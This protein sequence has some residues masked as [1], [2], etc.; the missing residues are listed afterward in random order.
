MAPRRAATVLRWT[1][2]VSFQA[3]TTT[4]RWTGDGRSQPRTTTSRRKEDVRS[5]PLTPSS[6]WR[7]DAS[8]QPRTLAASDPGGG[9]AS[10]TG[11]ISPSFKNASVKYCFL[12]ESK[13][14]AEEWRERLVTTAGYCC[15]WRA[16]FRDS[17]SF[18]YLEM[19]EKNIWKSEVIHTL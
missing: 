19:P 6:G 11:C 9:G 8:P 10:S 17:C 14:K 18:V 13:F 4:P 5:R 7:G 2:D 16:S 1:G 3:L 12:R 15:R